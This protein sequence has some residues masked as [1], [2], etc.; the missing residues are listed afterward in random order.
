M[1]KINFK[2]FFIII[3]TTKKNY[4]K[5]SIRNRSFNIYNYGAPPPAHL[6]RQSP[7]ITRRKSHFNSEK[8]NWQKYCF[9]KRIS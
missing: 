1:E 3:I 5:L 8:K 6:D 7:G 2:R 9:L 4:I